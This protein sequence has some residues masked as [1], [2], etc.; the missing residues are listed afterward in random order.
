[1]CKLWVG[2]KQEQK[3]SWRR[4]DKDWQPSP[5]QC[6]LAIDPIECKPSR[7]DAVSREQDGSDAF[8]LSVTIDPIECKPLRLDAATD[9]IVYRGQDGSHKQIYLFSF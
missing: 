8:I 5:A 4:A 9:L 2:R 6:S 3:L 1:M 7:L